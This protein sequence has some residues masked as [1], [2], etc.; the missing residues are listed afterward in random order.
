MTS[1]HDHLLKICKHLPTDYEPFGS[2]KREQGDVFFED[3]S[4]GCCWYLV[5]E[6]ELGGDW[7][8]CSNPK[9]PRCGLLTF[10]HQGCPAF[11]MDES[12]LRL[13]PA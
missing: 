10:E 8:V 3:C 7:G 6:G 13:P 5:L 4:A 9:S 1:A 11:E 12:S 2:M